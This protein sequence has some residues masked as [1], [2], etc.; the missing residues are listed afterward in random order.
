MRPSKLKSADGQY[1]P[2]AARVFRMQ[3][4]QKVTSAALTSWSLFRSPSQI[5][6]PAVRHGSGSVQAPWARA[7]G[8]AASHAAAH[9]ASIAGRQRKGLRMAYVIPYRYTFRGVPPRR[10]RGP[11]LRNSRSLA[12]FAA[13]PP[14]ARPP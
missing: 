3:S 6:L 10:P 13:Q 9:S 11:F 7:S 5:D 12:V 1:P 8:V 14:R 2:L 4:V